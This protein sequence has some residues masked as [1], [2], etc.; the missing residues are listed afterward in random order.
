[1]LYEDERWQVQPVAPA[2]LPGWMM[3]IARRHAVGLVG[4]DDEEAAGLGL[5]LRHL[6]R[7]LLAVTGAERIYSAALGEREPHFHLHMVPRYQVMPRD[8][9]GFAV[10]DLQRA[11]QTGELEVPTVEIARVAEAYRAALRATPPPR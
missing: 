10:F 2:C 7:V 1:M 5:L 9:R 4:L 8:A 11:A 6:E 3:L